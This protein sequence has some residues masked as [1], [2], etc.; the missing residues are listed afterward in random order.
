M[1]TAKKVLFI[2]AGA[3]TGSRNENPPPLGACL[4]PFLR[5]K[6]PIF[7]NSMGSAPYRTR[8]KEAQQIIDNYPN[9]NNFEKLLSLLKRVQREALHRAIQISFSDLLNLDIG[10]KKK[11]DLYDILLK[12]I[13]INKDEWIVISL[14]YDILLEDALY[15]QNVEFHYSKVPFSIDNNNFSGIPIFKPHGSINFFAQA[16]MR[17]SFGNTPPNRGRSSNLYKNYNGEFCV[18]HPLVYAGKNGA[19]N[20]GMNA[21]KTIV[22]PIIANFT[23]RKES[24]FNDSTL[25]HIRKECLESAKLCQELLIIGVCPILD[26]KHD[27]FC[28]DFFSLNNFQMVTFVT[29][30]PSRP[31]GEIDVIRSIYKEPTIIDRGLQ[32]FVAD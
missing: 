11:P 18:E 23:D 29:Y 12:K 24:D 17:F 26:K 2:G 7:L 14:N 21:A 10:F 1:T 19:L 13:N 20:V 16:D 30:S 9:E 25:Y 22:K 3:S 8:L 4:L 27:P 15:R 28:A 5:K 32:A 6:I 31:S